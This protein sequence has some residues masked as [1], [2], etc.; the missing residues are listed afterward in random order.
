[1]RTITLKTTVASGGRVFPV[2]DSRHGGAH[3]EIALG[4]SGDGHAVFYRVTDVPRSVP[5]AEVVRLFSGVELRRVRDVPFE[6]L[7]PGAAVTP[8]ALANP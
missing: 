4:P 6:C 7:A 1:M 8:K 3:P 5:L 2:H